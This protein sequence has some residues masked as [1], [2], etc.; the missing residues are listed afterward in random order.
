MDLFEELDNIGASIEEIE[1]LL[2]DGNAE[3]KTNSNIQE[4]SKETFVRVTEDL[5]EGWLYLAKPKEGESYTKEGIIELLAEN[6]IK[7]GLIMSNI[8]AMVKKGVYERSIK[9]ALYEEPK[10]GNNGYYQFYFDVDAINTKNPKIRPDGSVDY[11]SINILIGVNKDDK[12]CTYHR[13][14]EGVPGYLIDGTPIMPAPVAEKVPL[15]GIGFRYD[16]ETGDYYAEQTGKL[17]YRNEKE[18]F[19]RNVYQI[20]GDITQLNHRIEFNGDIEIDGSVESGS[21]IR[22]SGSVIISGVVEAAEIFAGGNVVLKRGV[23]G[24]NKAKIVTNGDVYADF[25]EH[26][27]VKA[28][29]S[30]NSNTILNSQVYAENQVILTGKRGTLVGGY[31]HGRQGIKCT[32]LGNNVEV[33]TVAHVGLETKDYL[34]NQDIMKKDTFL[35]EELEDILAKMNDILKQKAIRPLT[36]K[37]LESLNAM[38]AKK[39]LYIEEMKANR[40]EQEVIN[41]IIEESKDAKIVVEEHIYKGAIIA[42]DTQRIPIQ[43]NTQ[44]MSY[45]SVGGIIEGEVIVVN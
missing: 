10:E 45:K 16:E 31:T 3:G 8:T 42:I 20:K 27:T 41:K 38:N 40:K 1:K 30:V 37:D 4:K 7:A 39:D 35:R 14:K 12:I 21:V 24:S 25:I 33:K 44:F 9:V 19:I 43:A 11:T 2:Y 36:M 22:S 28:K 26:T 6:G 5:H 18:L 15:K 34:K 17:D 32:N 23:Q 29:G 13:A